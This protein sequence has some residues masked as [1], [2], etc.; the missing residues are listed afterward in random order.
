MALVLNE[1][2]TMLRDSAQAFL[3]E[4]APIAQ[5]R[6]L[7]DGRDAT[8]YSPEL[9]RG[10]ASMG[11]AG[12][13]VPEAHGGLGLGPIE[14][15]AI[16]EA[17]GRNLVASPFLSTSVLA[18]TALVHGGNSAQQ[19][20]WLPKIAAGEA[21]V[22]LAADESSKHRPN[23]IATRAEPKGGSFTLSGAKTFV[24][25]GHVADLLIVAARTAGGQDDADGVT[26]FLV[27]PKAKGVRIERTV[28]VDAHN[29]ARVSLDGVEVTADAVLGG[30]G[31]GRALLDTVLDAGR[32][33]L[34]S[35]M[36]GVADEAFERTMG[37]IKDRQQFGQPIGSF[38]ALQHRAAHLY[39]EIEV[40]RAA[41]IKAQQALAADPSGSGR[42]VSL[43][44]ARA[45]MSTTLAVQ[46]GVQ[47]HGG[48]GMTDDFD[49]GL[50]MKRLRVTQ[51]LF[52]DDA[53][54]ADRLAT[55]AGY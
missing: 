53:F 48:M 49:V 28:M 5:L 10:F 25:D 55:L 16:M 34:A 36:V 17:I 14:A 9:W 19:A 45:G 35:E 23:R 20:A 39:T 43:A 22:A 46:E 26:L 27:D 3:A 1:E 47:M 21:V 8:G 7:R 11:F 13:L 44:K 52:G 6:K 38:Q 33:A 2:Q 18:A 4:N 51:E 50:F 42:L 15:G 31:A 40:T 37:Y 32:A 30:V 29:A 12:A 54:H 41:V 24:V